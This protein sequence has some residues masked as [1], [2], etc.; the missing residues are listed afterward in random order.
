MWLFSL[1]C[2]ASGSAAESQNGGDM[3]WGLAFL[4]LLYIGMLVIL[5]SGCSQP[6]R[7]DWES[8]FDSA[9]LGHEAGQATLESRV[10]R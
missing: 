2:S 5:L 7:A 6:P 10:Q 8:R 3:P 9:M 4:A 1:G